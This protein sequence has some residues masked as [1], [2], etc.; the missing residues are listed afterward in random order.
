MR[1]IYHMVPDDMRGTTLYPLNL[2]KDSQPDLYAAEAAKYEGRE[3]LLQERI[4]TLDCLWN[5]VLHFT[6]VEPGKVERELRTAGFDTAQFKDTRWYKVPLDKLNKDLVTIFR[7]D[8]KNEKQ[9]ESYNGKKLRKLSDFPNEARRYYRE[10][11]AAG[12]RPLLFHGI[13]HILY[14]GALDTQEFEV[15]EPLDPG[16][17]MPFR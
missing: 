15:I 1:F 17:K 4:P 5:D 6:A 3:H 8:G 7:N 2:L 12:E 9:F 14:K 16:E 11:F 10:R 13:P